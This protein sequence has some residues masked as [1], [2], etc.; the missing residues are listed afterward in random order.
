MTKIPR[1][2]R[3]PDDEHLF[4][5]P[6]DDPTIR[7]D[8]ITAAVE[9]YFRVPA[10]WVGA[11]PDD[12][13]VLKLDP[14]IHHAEVMTEDLRSGIKVRVQRD[15]TFLFDFSR[16]PPAPS[17]L[18]PGYRIPVARMPHRA[19]KEHE[20]ATLKAEAIGVLRVQVMN[21]HQACLATSQRALTRSSS[22]VGLPLTSHDTLKGMTF[23]EALRYGSTGNSRD[24]V[25]SMVNNSDL[26]AQRHRFHR[27]VLETATVEHAMELF[28]R[29][30]S[31]EDENLFR[32][33][34]AVYLAAC[35]CQ[36][37]R[38]GEAMVLAWG[39]CEKLLT[40]AWDRTIGGK[41]E[42]HMPSVRKKKLHDRGYTASVR[43]EVLELMGVIGH[44]VY[45]Q[46]EQARR[47]RNLWAHEMREP[48]SRE[49]GHAVE[50]AQSLLQR[51][52][53]ISLSI[54][55]IASTPGVPEWFV[56]KQRELGHP[57]VS[58]R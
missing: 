3:S 40:I 17:I 35:R 38:L 12:A 18:I 51:F 13:S 44:Q 39:S 43:T 34:E 41:E 26:T 11:R 22:G 31:T 29:V 57:L 5:H 58:D 27:D 21:V 37:G 1:G 32:M 36:E 46:L 15:G 2:T 49:V 55:T 14:A 52:Y 23:N 50:A 47:A 42:E 54:P 25:R 24:I 20:T 8:S 30:V 9:G 45:R 33:V 10:V 56:W 16:W 7:L 4:Q 28:N 48:G 6:T 19:A 53:G